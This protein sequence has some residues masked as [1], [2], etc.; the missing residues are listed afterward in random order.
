M[1]VLAV[2]AAAAAGE[3]AALLLELRIA[4]ALVLAALGITLAPGGLGR[5][6]SATI[7]EAMTG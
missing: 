1:G 6:L 4:S 3:R 2:A 5:G 7:G